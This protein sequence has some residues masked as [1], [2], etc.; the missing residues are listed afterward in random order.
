MVVEGEKKGGNKSSKLVII[1]VMM[2]FVIILG[3]VAMLYLNGGLK[4]PVG[5][6]KPVEVIEYVIAMD[7]FTVN[8]NTEGRTNSYLKTEISF[9]YSDDSKTELFT[10]KKSRIRD[11]IIKDLMEYSSA[12]LLASGGLEYVKAKLKTEVNTVFGE[13]VVKEIYF[14]DFLIQ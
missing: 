3:V 4:L 12:E 9:M 14:T 1:V 6:D 5:K 13:D 8:L 7:S 10:E 11:I 2:N